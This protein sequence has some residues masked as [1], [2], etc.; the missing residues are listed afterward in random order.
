MYRLSEDFLKTAEGVSS[1]SFYYIFI[2][3]TNTT[4]LKIILH[5][6]THYTY[7]IFVILKHKIESIF[8]C[9]HIVH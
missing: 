7:I 6:T 4:G 2:Q 8:Y 3:E 9:L 5:I 1:Y